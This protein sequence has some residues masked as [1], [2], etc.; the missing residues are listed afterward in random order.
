MH[1]IVSMALLQML[2]LVPK[3]RVQ[4]ATIAVV[5]GVV[6]VLW[7]LEVEDK[8]LEGQEAGSI[9]TSEVESVFPKLY[10]TIKLLRL[11]SFFFGILIFISDLRCFIP[12]HGRSHIS[13]L[14]SVPVRF[15]ILPLQGSNVLPTLGHHT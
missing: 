1:I 15:S 14:P 4:A 5:G 8:G 9:H 7:Y 12:F 6:L 3:T 11:S 10:P 13:I 2:P